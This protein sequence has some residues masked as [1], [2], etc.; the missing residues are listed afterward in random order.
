MN[1]IHPSAMRKDLIDRREAALSQIR[2]EHPLPKVTNTVDVIPSMQSAV[3]AHGFDYRPRPSFQDYS[4]YS[5]GLIDA[6]I[7]HLSGSRAPDTILFGFL[8]I[9]GRIPSMSDGALWPEL[10]RDYD[11]GERYGTLVLLHRRAVRRSNLLRE[12]IEKDW[13]FDKDLPIPLDG[14]AEFVEID[15]HPN[16]F[17]KV[18]DVGFKEPPIYITFTLI[19]GTTEKYRIIPNLARRGFV[20]SPLVDNAADFSAFAQGLLGP[21]ESARRVVSLRIDLDNLSHWLYS[22]TYHVRFKSIDTNLLRP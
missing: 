5:D 4:T 3:I 2:K 20:V 14:G 15:I 18:A 7:Q 19:N 22:A 8:P 12:V 21:S 16:L 13:H 10:L 1:L 6:N 11:V 9:D 17:G